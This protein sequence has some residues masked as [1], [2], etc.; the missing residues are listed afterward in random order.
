MKFDQGDVVIAVLHSPRE[1]LLGVLD[2]IDPAGVTMRSIDLGYFDDW[3]SSIVAGEAHLEMNDNFY[4]MWRVERISRDESTDDLPSMAD[5]FEA[6]T[7][8]RLG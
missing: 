7:G 5:Q 2:S 3:C 8:R 6:R 4:P 1:K